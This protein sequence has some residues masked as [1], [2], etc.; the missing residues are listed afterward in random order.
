MSFAVSS[1]DPVSRSRLSWCVSMDRRDCLGM[2]YTTT[3]ETDL[4]HALFQVQHLSLFYSGIEP[5][6]HML[7]MS[8]WLFLNIVAWSLYVLLHA[9]QSQSVCCQV[10]A[11]DLMYHQYY[12]GVLGQF[13]SVSNRY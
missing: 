5:I 10:A 11:L 6:N 2:A 1:S 4:G 9:T 3:C 13:E 12:R 8:Q 7:E